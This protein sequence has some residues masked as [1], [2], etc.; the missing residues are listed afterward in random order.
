[1]IVALKNGAGLTTCADHDQMEVRRYAGVNV[2]LI[3]LIVI[4]T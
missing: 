2:G 1:M 4:H 3:D